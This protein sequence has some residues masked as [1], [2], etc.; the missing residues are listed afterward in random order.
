VAWGVCGADWPSIGTV[1]APLFDSRVNLTETSNGQDFGNYRS[2]RVNQMLDRAV[3][4]DDV[5]EQVRLYQRVDA[6]L[7]R[8]V[9]YIPLLLRRALLLRGSAV[10]GYVITPGSGSPDLGA[11][12]VAGP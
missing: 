11:I 1:L 8:D 7:G 2:D 6:R 5:A 4:L 10:R 3:A 9:A 12:S